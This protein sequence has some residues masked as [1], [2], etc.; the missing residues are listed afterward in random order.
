MCSSDLNL[1]VHRGM[2]DEFVQNN[3]T[4]KMGEHIVGKV[5]QTG[6]H[7]IIEDSKDDP[8]VTPSVVKSERYR[9]LICLPLKYREEVMAP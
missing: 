9:S 8:R 5:A 1:A 4:R 6:E 7:I 2:S 3:A